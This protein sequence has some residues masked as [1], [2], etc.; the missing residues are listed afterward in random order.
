MVNI[1]IC[2]LLSAE[3]YSYRTIL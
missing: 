3:K 2:G 1:I